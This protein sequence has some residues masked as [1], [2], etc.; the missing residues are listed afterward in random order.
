MKVNV[1]VRF[2]YVSQ[3][4][5]KPYDSRNFI[6]CTVKCNKNKTKMIQ[7]C[8]KCYICGTRLA[9]K[10]YCNNRNNIDD[11]VCLFICFCFQ[12]KYSSIPCNKWNWN[13]Q[14]KWMVS[15]VCILDHHFTEGFGHN[16]LRWWGG[17]VIGQRSKINLLHSRKCTAPTMCPSPPRTIFHWRSDTRA[18][19]RRPMDTMDMTRSL[20]GKKWLLG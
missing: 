6:D 2:W 20:G 13:K 19:G 11:K 5:L 18:M 9:L 1:P 15:W 4:N 8:F 17:G 16:P 10:T 14:K 3:C 7:G 12:K